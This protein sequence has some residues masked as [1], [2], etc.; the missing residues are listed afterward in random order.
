VGKKTQKSDTAQ[1]DELRELV[2]ES[3]GAGNGAPAKRTDRRSLLKMAGAAAL[4]AAGMAA[5]KVI[6]A[7]AATGGNF[8]LGCNNAAT[9]QTSLDTT[10]AILANVFTTGTANTYGFW[11]GGNSGS[12][13]IGVFGQSKTGTGTGVQGTTDSGNGVIGSASGTGTGVL[14]TASSGHGVS[15]TASTGVG[16]GGAASGAGTGVVG[17][18]GAGGIGVNG[19]GSTGYGGLFTS[20]TGY[21]L[22]AGFAALGASVGSGRLGMIGREDVGA[23]APNIAP[24]FFVTSTGHFTFEHEFVRGRDSSIWATRFGTSGTNQSRWKRINAVRVDSADGTGAVYAPFRVYD[25]RAGSAPK[26]AIGSTTTVPIAGQGT[27]TSAIPA[28]AV[29]VM[30]NLTATAYTAPGFLQLSPNGIAVTTSSVNFITGQAA[31]ANSFIVGLAGGAVQVKV[32]GSATHFIID[33]T[34]YIE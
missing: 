2:A 33:I 14:G 28:N 19:A 1:L 27:G 5:V 13:E 34:G 3:D 24:T 22:A 15:G 21:D 29:A 9:T 18:A 32:A 8:I 7:A 12:G 17:T 20:T 31:I 10:G 11:G 25:S 30:G 6:P 23:N 26:K 4:G 16:T